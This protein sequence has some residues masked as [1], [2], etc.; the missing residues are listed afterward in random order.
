MFKKSLVCVYIL[1]I[2]C[3][4]FPKP[5]FNISHLE[6]DYGQIQSHLKRP[7]K[8][9]FNVKNSGTETLNLKILPGCDCLSVSPVQI[10]LEPEKTT[11]ITYYFNTRGIFGK[12]NKTIIIKS[13][14][15]DNSVKYFKIQAVLPEKNN[16][17]SNIGSQ[18]SDLASTT[19][20]FDQKNQIKIDLYAFQDCLTCKKIKDNEVKKIEKQQGVTIKVNFI[21]MDKVEN[22]EKLLALMSKEGRVLKELPIVVV[23]NTILDGKKSI[24][25]NLANIIENQGSKQGQNENK[26]GVLDS[27][28]D[29]KNQFLKITSLGIIVAA[30]L[31]DGINPCAFSVIILLVSFL[32]ARSRKKNEILLA[33]SLYT[34]AVFISY[35][36]AGFGL[37]NVIKALLIF[38]YTQYLIKWGLTIFLLI[39]AVLSVYD[40][41]LIKIG[42]QDKMV[43]QLP[44]MLKKTIR[45]EFRTKLG[46]GSVIITPFILGIMVSAL[47][48]ACTGQVY[49]P[50]IVYMIKTG[51]N[52]WQ[53]FFYLFIYNFFFILPLIIVFLLVYFGVS[54]KKV[55]DS[56]VKYMATIKAVLAILFI[57]LAVLNFLLY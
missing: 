5:V 54:N 29:V 25:N 40:F 27:E 44:G 57:A 50:T 20:N 18:T 4:F 28:T 8:D 36:L 42:K 52:L 55:T 16:R 24:F 14:D 15:Q 3:Q 19:N 43:L 6:K 32:L 46:I 56:F 17:Q 51:Q 22:Y 9:S 23:G 53:N 48:F 38:K 10:S 45:K 33:G 39:L 47:E 34:L 26:T 11:D 1:I 49:L 35:F 37:F 21:P 7:I 12:T 13:N 41:Y 31:L 30:G 2:I